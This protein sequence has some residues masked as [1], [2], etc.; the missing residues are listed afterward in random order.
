MFR[1]ERLR[2]IGGWDERIVGFEDWELVLRASYRLGP[3]LMHP[4]AAREWR[5]HPGQWTA[6]YA[7]EELE[8]LSDV[9]SAFLVTL[10]PDERSIGERAVRMRALFEEALVMLHRHRDAPAA[11]GL[12]VR[13]YRA[14]PII[15]RS[16][17]FAPGFF[18]GIAQAILAAVGGSRVERLLEAT[19]TGVIHLLRRGPDHRGG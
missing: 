10:S 12:F 1:T 7:P 8:M 6:T 18:R 19:R 4:Y 11:L 17:M 15:A 9:V 3:V 2:S 5:K 16:P 13:A 14:A